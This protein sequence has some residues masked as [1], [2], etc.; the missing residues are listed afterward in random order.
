MEPSECI[1]GMEHSSLATFQ[2][3]KKKKG[4]CILRQVIPHAERIRSV[5]L[6]EM[7]LYPEFGSSYQRLFIKD[8]PRSIERKTKEYALADL[9]IANSDFVK[10][11][12]AGYPE[13]K[14]KVISIPT[15][16]PPVL[17]GHE[18]GEGSSGEKTVFLFAGPLS[19]RKG[20]HRLLNAWESGKGR[21]GEL[22]LAGE[23]QLEGMI[24]RMQQ[25][26]IKYWGKLGSHELERLYRE[27]DVLILPTLLEGL[28][29]TVLEALSAGLPVITTSASGCGQLVEH[30]CNGYRLENAEEATITEALDWAASHKKELHAMRSASKNMAR[31]W[32]VEASNRLH[33][34]QLRKFFKDRI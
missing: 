34:E 2:E 19:I 11:S 24:P 22:W 1:Y 17:N 26:G 20:V 6:Q 15:G 33:S 13:L 29:H 14:D 12:F 8:L 21:F 31:Q 25:K 23:S 4:L 3:Q 5:M 10:D 32:T 9:I 16:C 30:M 28:A 27:A 7:S 18:T